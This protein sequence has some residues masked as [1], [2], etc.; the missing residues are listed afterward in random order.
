MNQIIDYIA[1]VGIDGARWIEENVDKQYQSLLKLSEYLPT[2]RFLTL[3][4]KNAL[5]AFQL[6]SKGEHYWQEFSEY[7]ISNPDKDIVDFLRTSKGNRLYHNIKINRL[8]RIENSVFGIDYYWDM[9]KLRRELE[10]KLNSTGKT[11]FFAVKMYGYGARIVSKQFIPYPTSIPIPV[12]SRVRKI[13][14][15]IGGSDPER[16]WQEV[17]HQTGVPPLH[18]DSIIWPLLS[19]DREILNRYRSRFSIPKFLSSLIDL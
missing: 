9:N 7:F 8:E 19:G 2:D 15:R 10:L 3:I 1:G 6:T 11:I 5:I 4:V 13:T 17:S 16:F 14:E 12:D 18:I